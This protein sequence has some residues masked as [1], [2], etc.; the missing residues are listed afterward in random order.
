MNP[1]PDHLLSL[2]DVGVRFGKLT[3]L[4]AVTL[5]LRRGERL[6]LVG[7]NGSGKSTLLRALHGLVAVSGV[8]QLAP[9]GKPLVMAMLFQKPFMLDLSVRRNVL[10]GLWLRQ[11][12]KAERAARCDLALQRMGLSALAERSARSLSGGQQQRL[13]LARA[14]ALAPDVLLLDEP[15]ASLDPSGKREVELLIEELAAEGMTLVF[16]THNLGQAKRLATRVVYLDAGSVV[17]DLP[18]ALFFNGELPEQARLFLKGEMT[19]I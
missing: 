17:V 10:L 15:T 9:S 5:D 2:Q 12:P 16:S 14:W 3:A 11:V 7:A 8:R 4:Q 18:A 6:A 1:K 13:A 19:W